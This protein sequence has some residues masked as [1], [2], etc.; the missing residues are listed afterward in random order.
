MHQLIPERKENSAFFCSFPG[1]EEC[2]YS[3]LYCVLLY[4]LY[5]FLFWIF[6]SSICFGHP[7]W[8]SQ[9]LY[10]FWFKNIA[11]AILDPTKGISNPTVCLETSHQLP[12][13]SPAEHELS[14][15]FHLAFPSKL[16]CIGGYWITTLL[17]TESHSIPE[18]SWSPFHAIRVNGW[19][20][21]WWLNS[22]TPLWS[23][24][25]FL[26]LSLFSC[27]G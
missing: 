10:W 18:F 2:T 17:A 16:R 1:L 14:C 11:G 26:I 4:K 21:I 24:L 6:Q 19:H 20:H 27:N 8:N 9:K 12:G 13:G 7:F 23:I 15:T 25:F 22:I 5:F 3:S